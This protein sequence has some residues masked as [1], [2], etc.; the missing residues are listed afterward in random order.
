VGAGGAVGGPGALGLQGD[1]RE[2][3]REVWSVGRVEVGD[4]VFAQD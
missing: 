2:D 3:E 4:D 1:E